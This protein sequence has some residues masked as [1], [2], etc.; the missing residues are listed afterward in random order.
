MDLNINV[1]IIGEAEKSLEI[2]G[3]E[4]NRVTRSKSTQ[5][6]WYKRHTANMPNT[7]DFN[8]STKKIPTVPICP[9]GPVC[10]CSPNSNSG[11]VMSLFNADSYTEVAQ[12]T[13][14]RSY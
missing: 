2:S 4:Q 14:F 7:F 3:A 11:L 8:I 10:L 9:Y 13:T 1:S 5:L 6:V 12:S